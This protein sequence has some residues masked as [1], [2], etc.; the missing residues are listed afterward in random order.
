[1]LKL[2]SCSGLLKKVDEKEFGYMW[3]AAPLEDRRY[4]IIKIGDG[5]SYERMRNYSDLI[6]DDT[7]SYIRYHSQV[8]ELCKAMDRTMIGAGDLHIRGFHALGPVY[9]MHHPGLIQPI[10]IVLEWKQI[11]HSKVKKCYEQAAFL[12]LLILNECKC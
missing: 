4:T 8:E 11:E 9:A 2:W 7:K 6:D 10:Q 5:L 12:V 1:M 3:Q